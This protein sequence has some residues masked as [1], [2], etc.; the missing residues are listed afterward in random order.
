M[1]QQSMTGFARSQGQKGRYRWTWELRSVNGKGLD[2]RLRLPQGFDHLESAIRK[3]TAARLTRGNVQIALNVSVADS[4]LELVVNETALEAVLDLKNRLASRLDDSRLSLE[5]L[6][7]VR[8][9]AELREADEPG[10][11]M[12]SRE[13]LI[14]SDLELAIGRLAAMRAEEGE[15]IVAVLRE[16]VDAIEALTVVIEADRSRQPAV[17]AA[18]LCEQVQRLL[19][20]APSLEGDRLYAEAVLL[21]TKSDIR[22]ELDR[23]RAHVTA[24]R[25]LLG[26]P[27]P[28][29]RRLDFLAQ[30]FNRE[31]NTIC[32][33]SNSVEVTAAGLELKT[34]IDQFREQLQNLE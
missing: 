34:V 28:C 30:E 18:R 17:I 27:G 7:A 26:E 11:A 29:G 5:G 31:T 2:L 6:L 33:K 25:A 4:K 19:E 1:T 32:S 21:A 22:E 9:I 16:Q 3:L 20:A 24:A 14:V 12:A 15:K 13:A 10:D 23:L 8:G